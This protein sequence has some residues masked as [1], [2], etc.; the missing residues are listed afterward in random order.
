VPPALQSPPSSSPRFARLR[1]GF[2]RIPPRIRLVLGF[3]I[4]FGFA[5]SAAIVPLITQG[6]KV[7][8]EVAGS[9]PSDGVAGQ[10]SVLT[11]GIDN[12]GDGLIRPV[13]ITMSFDLPVTV[14]QVTVQGLDTVPFKD[15]RA[16]G[17]SLI[18]QETTSLRVVLLPEKAGTLHVRLVASQGSREIGPA[19]MRTMQ[20]APG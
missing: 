5:F 2:E 12:T 16:C 14:R 11:L 15:G 6:S 4:L 1:A 8:A 3:V 9:V 7:R 19:V 20:V 10:P 18:G 17:G 13:C